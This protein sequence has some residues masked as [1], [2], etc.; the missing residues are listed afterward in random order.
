MRSIA[1]FLALFL[2]FPASVLASE[3]VVEPPT[4]RDRGNGEVRVPLAHYTALLQ[5]LTEDPRPAPAAYA[6]G[7][8]QVSVTVEDRDGRHSARID[9]ALQIETFENEWTLV[10]IL[11]AGA[12]LRSA[13]VDGQPVQLVQTPQGLAW[14][15][16]R[17]GL[18]TMRVSYGL[19]AVISEAGTLLPIPLPRAAATR[20]TMTIPGSRRDLAV[21]PSADLTSQE[22]GAVTRY[23]ATIPATS[24]LLVTW[25][26]ANTRPY[27]ISRALYEGRLEG[28]ALI[29]T[30]R[31]QVELFEGGAITLPL[32]PSRVTLN[33][34]T[35]DGEAATV[36][37][38]K[39]TFATRLKGRGLHEIV[40]AFQVPVERHDG[41]PQATV[42]VPRIPVS[43]FDLV[44]PGRKDLTVNPLANVV[45]TT[46][47]AAADE[48]T[49]ARFFVP[50]TDALRLA[51]TEAVPEDLQA[52][53]R[54]NA[55]L[56]HALHAEEG[57]LHGRGV[58]LYEITRGETSLLTLTLPAAAQVNRIAAPGGGVSDWSVAEADAKGRK[59]IRV[60]LD[61]A[62]TGTYRLEVFYEQLLAAETDTDAISVPLLDAAGVHRQRGM[63]ALLAGPELT[64]KPV[65]EERLSRVGENQLPA[66]LRDRIALTVAHTYKYTDPAP[67]LV[68]AAVAPER[69]QGIFDA[70]VDTLISL[71]EVAMKGSATVAV[72]VKSGSI[73]ALSF[74]L[75]ATA[76]VL[77][78]TGPSLRSHKVRPL[79]GD[80]AGDEDGHQAIDLEFTR[81][82]AGQFR[83]EI[84]YEHI[85]AGVA[86]SN[87]VPT[88][89]VAGAEVEHGRVAVEALT[90][91]EVQATR[92][93]QLSG[94][95]INELPQ[96]L[97]LK[98]T[99]P[100]LLAYRYVQA[101]KPVA[102]ALKI[103]RHQEIQVQVAAIEQ[104]TYSTLFTRDG[105]AVTT[106]RLQ[107]RNS[108]RQFLRLDLPADSQVWSVFVNGK[109][110]KPA[111]AKEGVDG[112]REDKEATAILIRMINS[113]EGFPVEVVYATP[114]TDI[115]SF[116]QVSGHLPRPD[117]VVTQTRWDLFLP[118]GPHYL[119]PDSSMDLVSA[120]RRV[121]PRLAGAE[122]L[123][124]GADSARPQMGQPLRI[125][126]PTQGIHFAFEKL[127][128][129]QSDEAAG[130]SLRYVSAGINIAGLLVSALG[131][132]LLWLGIVAI[133]SRKVRLPRRGVVALLGLGAATLLVTL[134]YLG[135][136]PLPAS[137]LA[138]VLAL[139][140]G[141]WWI[142]ARLKAWRA[143]RGAA[144][145]PAVE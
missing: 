116:G 6:I 92:T 84:N 70:Q 88:V 115:A 123:L 69:Q 3:I 94:L 52:E 125:V 30:A 80:E 21:V 75:P 87:P 46:T 18:V 25:R 131:A 49:S 118:A 85:M 60:F 93:D 132:G 50:M 112:S 1:L 127:Y 19:D 9:A 101:K 76:N 122:T 7:Q 62:V 16:D 144:T 99:N 55:L 26:A 29:W 113:A 121:N 44:L 37:E 27:A 47:G 73:V 20:L 58:V 81:E 40:A 91:V 8:S 126:V 104:A 100:I 108:R 17:A 103:T 83:V 57:V 54:A 119:T 32:L 43:R 102:L 109:P 53:V 77:S 105:L 74:K 133:G 142:V 97:V 39:G 68:V 107:V 134:G 138:L 35:V 24:T 72:D 111:F 15:R 36:L 13:T 120:G 45:T 12:A 5:Q 78:V 137:A 33:D 82:M 128:A 63:V 136:S 2:A 10:P 98:T 89:S 106:A 48:T 14:S 42:P 96:Q 124:K 90:A 135:T 66:F 114:V 64:L 41:P 71:G 130:F 51:W 31:Y 79:E 22:E 110:E 61:R 141:I 86:A 23:S 11:P 117:M 140:L 38:D 67:T 95:D 56:Y 59:E 145:L 65:E 34:L 4:E 139:A 28:D 143:A 129:N